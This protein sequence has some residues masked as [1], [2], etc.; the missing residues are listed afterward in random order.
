MKDKLP[1][2]SVILPTYNNDKVLF[3][4]LDSIF[5][6]DYKNFEVLIID[7]GSSDNTLK[8]AKQ[9]NTKF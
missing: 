8:I 2:I 7:G 6:Q 4:C 1:L 9:F 5:K 3:N